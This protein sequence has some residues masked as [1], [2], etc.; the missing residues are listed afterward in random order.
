[1]QSQQVLDLLKLNSRQDFTMVY[2]WYFHEIL[3]S[4]EA[5]S[6]LLLDNEV[7]NIILRHTLQAQQYLDSKTERQHLLE[8]RALAIFLANSLSQGLTHPPSTP[9]STASPESTLPLLKVLLRQQLGIFPFLLLHVS[10]P[11][12]FACLETLLK[13]PNIPPE[14]HVIAGQAICA[15][16]LFQCPKVVNGNLIWKVEKI[17][18][19]L[20]TFIET[21]A[22][23]LPDVTGTVASFVDP[24]SH[25]ILKFTGASYC[26]EYLFIHLVYL[27]ASK[28]AASP[29][30]RKLIPQFLQAISWNVS[31]LMTNL[32]FEPLL[33]RQ[34]PE[35]EAKRRVQLQVIALMELVLQYKK[36]YYEVVE[37]LAG[38]QVVERICHTAFAPEC[39]AAFH[40]A[41]VSFVRAIITSGC[42][43]LLPSKLVTG[44]ITSIKSSPKKYPHYTIIAR[45]IYKVPEFA[46]YFTGD[47]IEVVQSSAALKKPSH[48]KTLKQVLAQVPLK[49]KDVLK[50]LYHMLN[51]QDHPYGLIVADFARKLERAYENREEMHQVIV[52]T[53]DLL[54]TFSQS[55]ADTLK[56]EEI[57][58]NV[59]Q[60]DFESI[61]L[62]ASY[63]AICSSEPPIILS[64]YQSKFA[65]K[66]KTLYGVCEKLAASITPSQVNVPS[67]LCPQE[68]ESNNVPF[69]KSIFIFK[70]FP[71]KKTA[72]SK[73]QVL[74]DTVQ[75]ICYS[76][77][78]SADLS[79]SPIS[80][81][82]LMAILTY[83]IIKSK[84]KTL[85]S[86][87]EFIHDFLGKQHL[88]GEQG[89][90]VTTLQCCCM[91]ISSPEFMESTQ[92]VKLP[93]S[94]STA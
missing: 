1:M 44:F 94:A 6:T 56:T 18:V 81:D 63:E 59:V 9:P 72:L 71:H 86:E 57:S 82:D 89:Y 30:L 70:K 32:K 39:T 24:L 13:C 58:L 67:N 74:R 69:F 10:E 34:S 55:I 92:N 50:C 51:S 22:D 73:V 23:N 84:I 60:F 90:L 45:E 42:A 11:A 25:F 8:T 77:G 65:E 48:K 80:A 37:R 66:D 17:A 85:V 21:L 64:S 79:I 61:C 78:Q 52:E 5:S 49:E 14:L 3:V 19:L 31:A 68:T 75:S 33:R 16:F 83:V 76:T 26:S 12:I 2:G 35:S 47:I 93:T 20:S 27:V 15:E 28:Y 43:H 29:I 53:K 40:S 91:F 38:H 36:E 62:D 41:G 87:S 7:R 88:A 4:M 46:Q 54:H